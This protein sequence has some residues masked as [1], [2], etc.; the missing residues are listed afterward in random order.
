MFHKKAP[1]ANVLILLLMIIMLLPLFLVVVNAIKPLTEITRN[2]LAL[3]SSLY[4]DNITTAYTKMK[5]PRAFWNTLVITMF[6][7][8]GLVLFGTM[9]GYWLIRRSNKFNKFLYIL[10][11]G[12]MA[13]PFQTVMIPLVQVYSS[14]GMLGS[15]GTVVFSYWGMGC[16][17]VIF[18]TYGTIKSIPLEIEEAAIIDGC[19]QLRL[20]FSI[21]F[22]L[23]RTIVL[24]FTILNTFWFWNDF[25]LPRLIIGNIGELN[26][27]QMALRQ[28]KGEYIARW[29]Y[30]LGGLCISVIPP[31]VF[32]ISCQKKMISG[33]VSGAVKG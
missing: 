28:F 26:T 31:L 3:P 33:L 17:T 27:I 19:S 11:L 4:L 10:F 2:V 9:T 14:L 5:F 20:Y 13:I 21:I 30:L 32:F 6:S 29:D 24:T 15:L 22:P 7:N 18:L 16:S 8:L 12:A 1:V 25:L 23:L